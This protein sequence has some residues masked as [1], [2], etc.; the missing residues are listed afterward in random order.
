MRRMPHLKDQFLLN[1]KIHFLNHGSFGATPLP[2]FQDYQRWQG[3]LERQPVKFLG[4]LSIQAYNTEE[5]IKALIHALK[6][7]LSE[8]V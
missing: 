7:L 8:H 5:D 2:V 1:P 4:R 3:E 6:R